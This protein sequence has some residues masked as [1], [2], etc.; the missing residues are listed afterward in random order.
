[1]RLMILAA[2][3]A[4]LALTACSKAEQQQTG[5]DIKDAAHEVGDKAKEAANSPEVKK[6]GA[7]IKEAAKDTAQVAGGALKGAAEGAKEGAAEAKAAVKAGDND[8][9]EK[10]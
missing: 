4:A 5:A 3:G 2:A 1:M 9:D 10:K 8:H 7:E 6:A